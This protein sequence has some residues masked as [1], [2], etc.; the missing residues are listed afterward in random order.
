MGVAAG[1]F[2]GD[3]DDDLFVVNLMRE[4]ATLFRREAPLSIGLP[5]FVDVTRPSGLYQITLPYTGFGTAWIDFDS[6]GQLDLFVANGAVTLREEQ[7]G[8][9]TP[10]KE[11]NL[12]IHNLGGGKF[13]DVTASAGKVFELAEITRGAAFGDIDNDGDIDIVISNNNGPA[14]LLRN[15]SPKSNWL[16]VQATGGQV[17]G[18]RVTLLRRNLRP[19]VR[20]IHTDSSY[21]SASD[22]RVHFGLGAGQEIDSIEVQW[23]NGKRERWTNVHPNSVLSV[24]PGAGEPIP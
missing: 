3:G 12:L 22:S 7:R 13:A 14:G 18:S 19:L 6:D 9:P 1:D 2:D 4:G 11:R 23:P 20:T 5:M 10:Y 21:C 24:R 8:Q 17:L 16:Q 15:E